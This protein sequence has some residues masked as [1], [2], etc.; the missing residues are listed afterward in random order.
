[1]RPLLLAAIAGA[2]R[3][4]SARPRQARRAG[5]STTRAPEGRRAARARASASLRKLRAISRT[6]MPPSSAPS[7]RSRPPAPIVV[8]AE[9]P[10]AGQWDE[11]RIRGAAVRVQGRPRRPTSPAAARRVKTAG[12][13]DRL[14]Q[15]QHAQARCRYFGQEMFEQAQAKG[16]LDRRGLPR[17][18]R[19]IAALAGPQGI[20]AALKA[21]QLDALV[22][23]AGAPAWLTD[24]VNGDHF[25]GARLWRR[26][27]RGLSEHHRADGRRARPAGRHRVP[28]R[29]VERS[30]R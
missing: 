15:R 23:P 27:G 20:D 1:M 10:T 5:A 19:Q 8:D 3:R 2:R 22:A 12:R 16:P 24:P 13:P 26:R 17:R 29:G 30:A 11:R 18:P 14:Q 25:T 6:S 4:R 28:G 7:R 9:I 21:Q